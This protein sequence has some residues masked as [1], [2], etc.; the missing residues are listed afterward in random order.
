MKIKPSIIKITAAIMSG[1]ILLF[2]GQACDKHSNIWV[3]DSKL[4]AIPTASTEGGNGDGYEGKLLFAHIEPGFTCEGKTAP[5]VILRRDSDKNWYL[6]QNITD[7]CANVS[8][9]LVTGVNY[10]AS[11]SILNFNQVE[12]VQLTTTPWDNTSLANADLQ[13][14]LSPTSNISMNC[15]TNYIPIPA[16][17]PYTTKSFCVSKYEMKIQGQAIGVQ[18]YNSAFVPESRPDGTPWGS[19]MRDD[20]IAECQSLGPAFDLVSND[21][22]QTIAQNTELQASNW[23]SLV[24]GVEG[25]YRGLSDA[26]SVDP[27]SILDTNDYYDQT[28]NNET[29]LRGFGKE[30]RRTHFL[31]NGEMIWDL[32]GN[33]G[34][35]VKDDFSFV[36]GA[37]TY[38]YLLTDLL[39]PLLNP[40]NGRTA[41][42]QFGPSGNYEYLAD[43]E[44]GGLG[45]AWFNSAGTQISRGQDN[46][47]WTATGVFTT[48][49]GIIATDKSTTLGFRC[50]FNP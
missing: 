22:W 34:E 31:S 4:T 9:Q 28:G 17:A 8:H 24:V 3:M 27:I 35:W 47:D 15:P 18:P 12:L 38:I 6:T 13:F 40:T 33:A 30:Q 5:T 39:Y 21:Q 42:V 23:T 48:R 14:P 44:V 50:V 7:K 16:R 37:D 2:V 36:Y 45:Y 46:N 1:F 26:S 41:K 29:Q 19:I 25:M 32:A 20:A 43:H 11:E 10:N 49:T